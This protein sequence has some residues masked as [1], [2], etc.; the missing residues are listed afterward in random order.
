LTHVHAFTYS[1]RY[2][3]ASA[4]MRD[5]VRGDIAKARHRELSERIASKNLA[6]R[7]KHDR[8]LTVLIE[9]GKT[10]VYNGFDQYFNRVQVHSDE[11]LSGNWINLAKVSLSTGKSRQRVAYFCFAWRGLALLFVFSLSVW[12]FFCQ[13]WIKYF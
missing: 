4:S 9:N 10:G 6:F 13:I 2:G 8:D 12:S 11:D 3:T 1:Q 5:I 7:Q